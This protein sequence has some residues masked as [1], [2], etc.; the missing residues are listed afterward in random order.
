MY[1]WLWV[2]KNL[3]YST[4]LFLYKNK[5]APHSNPFEDEWFLD[6]SI[7]TP[8]KSDFVNMTL[9]NYDQDYEL[10]STTL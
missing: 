1:I 4:Y 7:F 3:F 9:G 6:S 10:K 5:K 2:L 8:F